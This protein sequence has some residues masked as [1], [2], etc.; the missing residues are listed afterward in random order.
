MLRAEVF[1][2]GRGH[3]SGR[4]D[5][6][7]VGFLVADGD[8]IWAEPPDNPHLRKVLR[9]GMPYRRG[10]VRTE[11]DLRLLVGR[12]GALPYYGLREVTEPEPTV[13]VQVAEDRPPA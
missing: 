6:P 2:H 8:R 4:R 11:A 5:G 10:P 7:S 13:I 9:H 12:G 3:Y 1:D